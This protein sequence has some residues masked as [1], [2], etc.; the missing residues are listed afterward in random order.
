MQFWIYIDFVEN[1]NY[2]KEI[3]KKY[4]MHWR[5]DD[6]PNFVDVKMT[7]AKWIFIWHQSIPCWVHIILKIIFSFWDTDQNPWEFVFKL[8]IF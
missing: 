8:L 6:H 3:L 1:D 4:N 5:I 2:P 7:A